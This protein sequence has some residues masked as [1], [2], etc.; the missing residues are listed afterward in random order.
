MITPRGGVARPRAVVWPLPSLRHWAQTT[1]FVTGRAQG[2]EANQP[3]EGMLFQNMFYDSLNSLP[4]TSLRRH[5]HLWSHNIAVAICNVDIDQS[6]SNE[7]SSNTYNLLTIK[8][9]FII[10]MILSLEKK[11]FAKSILKGIWAALMNPCTP[12]PVPAWTMI[13]VDT[14]KPTPP[15][16]CLH[17]QTGGILP[18][19]QVC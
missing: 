8:Y 2:K 7:T 15:F 19:S 5:I 18:D 11:S 17:A 9:Y 13:H 4:L 10:D 6:T 14:S 1:N 3:V 16:R 12:P